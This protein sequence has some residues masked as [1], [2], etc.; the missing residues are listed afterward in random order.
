LNLKKKNIEEI[1]HFSSIFEEK[2]ESS[3]SRK[4]AKKTSLEEISFVKDEINKIKKDKGNITLYDLD[5]NENE[6][7]E[8]GKEII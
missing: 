1:I 8:K 2:K 7:D 5:Y 4:F 6:K 3:Y